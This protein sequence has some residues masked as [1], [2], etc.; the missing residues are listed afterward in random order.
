MSDETRDET[1]NDE[2]LQE[3]VSR[4]LLL[5]RAAL[6]GA[7]V[8]AGAAAMA[9]NETRASAQMRAPDASTRIAAP[10]LDTPFSVR[11]FGARGDG[12][13]DD[14][15]A[16]Q[17]AIDAAIKSGGG[18]VYFPSGNYRITR[19]LRV[20]S[21]ARIDITGDGWS[22]NL[23]HENDEPLLLWP[24][25]V[26]CRECSVRNLR[27]LATKTKSVA[28]PVIA[29]LGGFE[30]SFFQHLL[31]IAADGAKMGSGV[32]SRG[33]ADTTTF[34]HCL[35]WGVN[36]TGIEVA[37]G[38]EVRIFGGRIVGTFSRKKENIGVLL[39]GNNG[40]VHIVTTDIIAVH[41]GLQI[42]GVGGQSNREVCITHAT[43]DSSVYGVRQYDNTYTSIAGC[44]AASSDEAQIQLE[45]S[46]RGALLSIAGGTI[47]NGGAYNQPTGARNGLVVRAGSFTLSGV[48][49]RY[50]IG[51]GI[52]VEGEGV[53]DYTISGCRIHNN[54]TGAIFRSGRRSVTGNVFTENKTDLVDT[55]RG[56]NP[57][58]GNLV[59]V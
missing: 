33:V 53:G 54:G 31:F 18:H 26:E 2:G 43:F 47:F 13:T 56:D 1:T 29:C 19:T 16:A 57:F 14:T 3:V 59:K 52:L 51:T 27:V 46:A 36:G 37:R 34:D 30:R 28:T 12:K 48:S 50:N 38:S 44:W 41:T 22:S 24:E 6:A 40:G 25:K 58:V 39:T 9:M 17:A 32:I 49:V 10:T 45:P 4:R 20:G 21:V 7:G 8:V 15:R 5:E 55:A 42:G 35:M 11:R 23:L